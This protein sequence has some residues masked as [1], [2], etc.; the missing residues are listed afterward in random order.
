VIALSRVRVNFWDTLFWGGANSA[1]EWEGKGFDVV[2]SLPDYLYLDFP[3]EV[4]PE[5]RGYYWGTRCE[6]IQT[7]T[8]TFCARSNISFRKLF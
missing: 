2:L 6:S 5:E 7:Q 3:N 4:H 8:D 1:A